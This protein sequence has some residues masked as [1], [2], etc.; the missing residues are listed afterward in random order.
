MIVHLTPMKSVLS[1]EVEF[2]FYFCVLEKGY[3]IAKYGIVLV[4]ACRDNPLVKYF[5]NGKHKG[6]S[7][8][9]G[10]GQVTPTT[11]QVVIGFATS[12]GD[13][14]DD[15]NENMSPYARALSVR[16]KEHDDIRNILGKVA[17]D[18]SSKYEQQ[19][20]YRA[21]LAESVYLKKVTKHN[22]DTPEN[23]AS[24]FISV[25]N[26][27]NCNEL[28]NF[29]TNPFLGDG[30]GKINTHDE[31][32]QYCKLYYLEN[33]N[34]NLKIESIIPFDTLKKLRPDIIEY[35]LKIGLTGDD[36]ELLAI[37]FSGDK[38]HKRLRFRLDLLV[39]QSNNKYYIVGD[40]R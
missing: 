21:N 1:A 32:N 34:K 27:K 9:K 33:A 7:A 20:I 38:K 14:A 10:L 6:S 18:V 28:K 40:M 31:F 37:S 39:L 23:F 22:I 4:D 24:S 35:V 36:I 3:I 8:K 30:R 5:Q 13:T 26:S 11:G 2:E 12:A 19:P 15:G 25:L 16:L 17:D 29:F